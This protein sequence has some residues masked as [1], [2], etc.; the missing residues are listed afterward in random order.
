MRVTTILLVLIGVLGAIYAVIIVI[1]AENLPDLKS[2]DYISITGYYFTASAILL[3]FFQLRINLRYNQRK[4]AAD[5][6]FSLVPQELIPNLRRVVGLVGGATFLDVMRGRSYQEILEGNGLSSRKLKELRQAVH[7][8][9]NFYE[10]MAITIFSGA[11]DDEICYDD[12][13]FMMVQFHDWV[14]SYVRKIQE[15]EGVGGDRL[16]SN[17]TALAAHWNGKRNREMSGRPWWRRNRPVDGTIK[18]QEFWFRR[19]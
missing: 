7:D 19:R 3:A 16:F 18:G 4:A 10:R 11:L 15:E 8:I 1:L 12:S 5:F 13:G 17:F 2:A 6:V 9:L 14:G